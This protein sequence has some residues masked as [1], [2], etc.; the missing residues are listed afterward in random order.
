MQTWK[1]IKGYEGLYSVSDSGH[2]MGHVRGRELKPWIHK[3]GYTYIT[4]KK[5]GTNKKSFRLHRL[6][7]TYFLENPEGLPAVNH[8]DGNKEN[9]RVSNLE[10]CTQSANELH[11]RDT[12]L[13]PGRGETHHRAKLTLASVLEIKRCLAAGEAPRKIAENYPI[14]VGTIYDIRRGKVWAFPEACLD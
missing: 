11:A 8:L 1:S 5:P 7:A 2:V 9:N 14:C 10:W 13:N 4:I 3:S 12:G 6:V